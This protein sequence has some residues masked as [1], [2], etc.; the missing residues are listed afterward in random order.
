[1]GRAACVRPDRDV[2]DMRDHLGALLAN[3]SAFSI[4]G[5]NGRGL[6][7]AHHAPEAYARAIVE[8]ATAVQRFRPRSIAYTLAERA[9]VEMRE[10]SGPSVGDQ[11]LGKV[12]EEI[13]GMVA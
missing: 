8:F 12:A 3:P 5:Q 7:E 2:Q 10:W 6:L 4:Q 9:S 13:T 11:G 1:S